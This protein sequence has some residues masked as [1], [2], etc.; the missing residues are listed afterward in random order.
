MRFSYVAAILL[1]LITDQIS[2]WWVVE[3]VIKSRALPD[4]ADA[5]G[6]PFLQWLITAQERMPYVQVDLLPFFNVVMVWNK[7]ISFG[8]FNSHSDYGPVLLLVLA[9]V[10]VIAFTIWLRRTDSMLI[11]S[12][13]VLIIGGALGNMLDRIR[14]GAVADFL[15]FHI[16][17]LHWPAFN[18]ADSTIC[19]GIAMLLIHGLFFDPKK[20]STAGKEAAPHDA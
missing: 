19:I 3:H 2:K 16:A 15:D 13:L 11:A 8:L 4:R 9:T 20:H 7:G 6:M 5:S 17:G 18:V 10:I 12:G 14:F 1:I